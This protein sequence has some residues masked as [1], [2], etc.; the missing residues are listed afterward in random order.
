MEKIYRIGVLAP[1]S[2]RY[3]ALASDF[4]NCLRRPLSS[5]GIRHELLVE[6]IGFGNKLDKVLEACQK[7]VFSDVDVVV[8]LLGHR[9]HDRIFSFFQ[10]N[11]KLLLFSDFGSEKP[12]IAKLGKNIFANSLGLWQSMRYGALRHAE[13]GQSKFALLSSFYEAGYGIASSYT[14]AMLESGHGEVMLNYFYPD[15]PE[16]GEAN[17]LLGLLEGLEVDT[18]L[19]SFSGPDSARFHEVLQE[20]DL[21]QR[22][23]LCSPEG[24]FSRDLIFEN[25]EVY[26]GME[27]F[28]SWFPEL[29]SEANQS[30][31]EWFEDTYE[32][33]PVYSAL[34]GFENG[35]ALAK[36]I[37]YAEGERKTK[38]LRE[39]MEN[40]TV[41]G[42]RGTI[43]FQESHKTRPSHYVGK[44][45]V[46]KDD[47]RIEVSDRIDMDDNTPAEVTEGERGGWL[48]AYMCVD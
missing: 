14:E 12:P 43:D 19:L 2:G 45:I 24:A 6:G 4:V 40:V 10:D 44:V 42:P 23:R 1:H 39:A 28:G 9:F 22:L 46:D 35:L 25:P 34:L 37:E 17:R 11:N 33:T 30:F 18:A 41:E 7:L 26:A 20:T 13:L 38:V 8:A 5:A 48:N 21:G 27:M 15:K 32:R 29:E 3:P 31:L 16:A 36:A 47:C